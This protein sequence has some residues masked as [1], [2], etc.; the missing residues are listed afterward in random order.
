MRRASLPFL[1]LPF[2]A[3]LLLAPA[4]A[5]AP[6]PQP[7]KDAKVSAPPAQS[8]KA[9]PAAAKAVAEAAAPAEKLERAGLPNLGKVSDTLYR[10]GQPE[11]AGYDALKELGVEIVVNLRDEGPSISAERKEVESRGMR[12]VSL[13]WGA[14]SKPDNAEVAEFLQLLR[15]NPDKSVYVHC[16]RGAE[17]TGVMVSAYR[18]SQQ[19]WTPEQALAEMEAF[20]FRGF[21]F[22]YLKSYVRKFPEL[23]KSDP[24][25]R[26][27]A[28][29]PPAPATATP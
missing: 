23:L 24:A 9:T 10:G 28:A 27:L 20:K 19:G 11:E 17:R 26:A 7:V 6:A 12:F 14:L 16:K 4:W 5:Q 2:A 25:L 15:D 21:W 18:M 29:G 1:T 3:L 13:P 22:W 8:A